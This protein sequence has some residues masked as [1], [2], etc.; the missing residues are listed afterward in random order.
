MNHEREGRKT[1]G[2][3]HELRYTRW[4]PWRLAARRR[5]PDRPVVDETGHQP[6]RRKGKIMGL[7]ALVLTTIGRK[8]GAERTVP[9]GWFPGGNGSWL[10]LAAANGGARNPGWYYNIAAHP[11][12]VQ[13]ETADR[14]V[15]VIAEQLHGTE[16]ER[17]WRQITAAAP[18]FAKYQ[19]KTDREL[20]II[21][22]TPRSG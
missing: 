21:R 18:R 15:A 19:R 6:D 22:L 12:N 4:N 2:K 9:V 1:I 3:S 11:D 16:R 17:A 14:K 5:R 7:D 10:I 13:I 20:P 8:S